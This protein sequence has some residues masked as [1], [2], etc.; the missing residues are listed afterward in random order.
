MSGGPVSTS[1]SMDARD[2]GI[3]PGIRRV[4]VLLSLGAFGSSGMARVL[5][6]LLPRLEQEFGASLAQ[7]AWSLTAFAVVYGVLQ[8]VYGPLADRHGK[9]RVIRWC[10]A[11]AAV[12]ALACAGAGDSLGALIL[13]RAAAG[14]FCAASI[15]LAIAW[16]GDRVPMAQRKTVLAQ[17]MTGQMIGMASGQLLGGIAAEHAFW[18]W[19]FLVY[20]A[21]YAL[22]AAVLWRHDDPGI[23]AVGVPAAGSSP[24]SSLRQAWASASARL[25]L[26]SSFAEGMLYLGAFSYI[27]TH[28]HREGG[29]P[30]S[31]AGV[32]IMAFSLG[33]IAF[34]VTAS[35]WLARLD[36]NTVILLGGTLASAGMIAVALLPVA[37]VVAP[38]MVLGG[39]GFY[40]LHNV[41]QAGATQMLPERRG[42]A[43]AL[44]ATSF[45]LGQSTGVAAMGWVADHLGT[46]QALGIGAAGLFL[47]C[48]GLRRGLRRQATVG[49]AS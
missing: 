34:A 19:P 43:I 20:A 6:P 1:A 22:V 24:L 49:G 44:F 27:A 39:L 28:L 9:L 36:E 32:L 30:L 21:I 47:L 25:I 14:A 37:A 3:A 13:A 29:M 46:T 15:P 16:I 18:S 17:F 2:A 12:A 5:D 40:M 4:I 7:V 26:L 42:A 10:S 23:A 8:L 48:Q 31:Q 41:L 11:G 33:G 38:A 35:R 45:F